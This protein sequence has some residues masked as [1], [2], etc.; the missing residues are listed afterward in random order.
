[1]SD[2]VCLKS[3]GPCS[4][5]YGPHSVP[6]VCGDAAGRRRGR[7]RHLATQELDVVGVAEQQLE[8]VEPID[9]S[10][11]LTPQSVEQIAV[12]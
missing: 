3:S 2:R 5:D 4:C 8:F 12:R 6:D 11:P 1:M 9:S 7:G 10:S